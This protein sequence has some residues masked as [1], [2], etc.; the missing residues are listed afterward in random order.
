[1]KSFFESAPFPLVIGLSVVGLLV[2]AGI[3]LA[4][5]SDRRQR[6]TAAK[7][8]VLGGAWLI[9]LGI[10]RGNSMKEIVILYV[11][12]LILAALVF[13]GF[14]SDV[15]LLAPRLAAGEKNVPRI[16]E[17]RARRVVFS[18]VGVIALVIVLE[19]LPIWPF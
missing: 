7:A 6:L 15:K 13:V 18:A 2:N 4:L 10:I 19:V 9:P 3:V 1:M 16:P 14:W 8:F 11:D 5:Y 12:V 17:S